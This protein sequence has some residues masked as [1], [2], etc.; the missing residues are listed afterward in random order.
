MST[1]T[2][3]LGYIRRIGLKVCVVL[4]PSEHPLTVY[5]RSTGI[6]L[7]YVPTPLDQPST[8]CHKNFDMANVKLSMNSILVG[9]RE[10]VIWE[11]DETDLV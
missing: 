8:A 9:L 5:C 10:W 7:T 2:R 1:V 4:L 11:V 3:T 6:S